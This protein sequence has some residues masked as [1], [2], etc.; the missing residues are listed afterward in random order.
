M[1]SVVN[2]DEKIGKTV[3][4]RGAGD[5]LVGAPADRRRTR[6]WQEAGFFPR[7]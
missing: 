5:P 1:Q 6:E 7:I 3:G 2:I 4:R